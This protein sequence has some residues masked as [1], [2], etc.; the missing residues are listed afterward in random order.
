MEGIQ[1]KKLDDLAIFSTLE[2]NTKLLVF[3]KDELH[4]MLHSVIF[5][6][7]KVIEWL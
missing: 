6:T 1:K 7:D 4:N 5:I 3:G 2:T